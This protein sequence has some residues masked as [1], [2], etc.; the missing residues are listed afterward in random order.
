M[1]EHI[2]TAVNDTRYY[3]LHYDM[4]SPFYG[5][6]GEGN[7]DFDERTIL[8]SLRQ[9][10]LC[11][12]AFIADWRGTRELPAHSASQTARSVQRQP[13]Y[14]YRK[15]QKSTA[16]ILTHGWL[17][18]GIRS[19]TATVVSVATVPCDVSDTRT[20]RYR[21]NQA[22]AIGWFERRS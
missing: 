22:A 18:I 21:I 4:P 13:P 20:W 3:R 1:G 5:L 9:A 7:H 12:A 2:T 6:S 11:L 10:T 15:S 19:A 17:N 14:L 16:C 8:E